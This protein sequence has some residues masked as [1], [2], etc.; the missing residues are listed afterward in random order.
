MGNGIDPDKSSLQQIDILLPEFEDPND[1]LEVQ[2][3]PLA[4]ITNTGYQRKDDIIFQQQLRSGYIPR[5]SF[6][7]KTKLIEMMGALDSGLIV[8]QH[9]FGHYALGFDATYWQYNEEKGYFENKNPSLGKNVQS[10][11]SARTIYPSWTTWL[12]LYEQSYLYKNS[13][14]QLVWRSA[15]HELKS[16]WE[17]K[18]DY[19]APVLSPEIPLSSGTDSI[20]A[21]GFSAI[22]AYIQSI[23]SHP[24]PGQAIAIDTFYGTKL[25]EYYNVKSQ[26]EAD[27]SQ[28]GTSNQITV[29]FENVIHS[30]KKNPTKQ[31]KDSAFLTAVLF[32]KFKKALSIDL[33][34]HSVTFANG[35]DAL[36][37]LDFVFDRPNIATPTFNDPAYTSMSYYLAGLDTPNLVSDDVI[38][39]TQWA[40]KAWDELYRKKEALD[41]GAIGNLKIGTIDKSIPFGLIHEYYKVLVPLDSVDESTGKGIATVVSVSDFSTLGENNPSYADHVPFARIQN[42]N[43]LLSLD[44]PPGYRI[45]NAQELTEFYTSGVATLEVMSADPARGEQKHFPLRFEGDEEHFVMGQTEGGAPVPVL[46]LWKIDQYMR[47]KESVGQIDAKEIDFDLDGDG[48]GLDQSYTHSEILELIDFLSVN[49]GIQ[50]GT[51]FQIGVKQGT[52]PNI[53]S[54]GQKARHYVARIDSSIL[55]SGISDIDFFLDQYKGKPDNTTINFE[56]ATFGVNSTTVGELK[57]YRQWFAARLSG[58]TEAI[59]EVEEN[60]RAAETAPKVQLDGLW[61]QIMLGRFSAVTMVINLLM[62]WWMMRYQK[63][64]MELAEKQM[65]MM[66]DQYKLI[67]GELDRDD[68]IKIMKDT[69]P[70]KLETAF[71]KYQHTGNFDLFVTGRLPEVHTFL[72]RTTLTNWKPREGNATGYAIMAPGGTGKDFLI[73]AYVQAKVSGYYPLSN[74]Q[75]LQ[76]FSDGEL[77]RY[78]AGKITYQ[79]LISKYG[80]ELPRELRLRWTD[81]AGIQHL[82]FS[83]HDQTTQWTDAH[84]KKHTGFAKKQP[85]IADMKYHELFADFDPRRFQAGT[86]F[87]GTAEKKSKVI[88]EV[89]AD[90]EGFPEYAD[91]VAI[92]NEGADAMSVGRNS[93]TGS[94]GVIKD[95]KEIVGRG[96]LRHVMLF[97]NVDEHK[98]FSPG[99]TRDEQQIRR[100]P[101]LYTEGFNDMSIE[102]T[103]V[104]ILHHLLKKLRDDKK[105]Q[106]LF[107]GDRSELIALAKK[108]AIE[109]GRFFPAVGNP[110]RSFMLVSN[111]LASIHDRAM[112]QQLGPQRG[113]NIQ[114]LDVFTTIMP[115]AVTG[116]LVAEI[117]ETMSSLTKDN[118]LTLV[119]LKAEYTRVLT[120]T[121]GSIDQR[122]STVPHPNIMDYFNHKTESPLLRDT[123]NGET[124]QDYVSRI[125]A[126]HRFVQSIDKS[127]KEESRPFSQK[128]PARRALNIEERAL[129]R[130]KIIS[131]LAYGTEACDEAGEN[132]RILL[133]T[134]VPLGSAIPTV[135]S[136][137]SENEKQAAFLFDQLQTLLFE[138]KLA[139]ASPDQVRGAIDYRVLFRVFSEANNGEKSI[140]TV[141]MRRLVENFLNQ[142]KGLES[143]EFYK[144][145]LD[146]FSTFLT[147]IRSELE[148]KATPEEKQAHLVTKLYEHMKLQRDKVLDQEI[149]PEQ[150]E[151]LLKQQLK[152]EKQS[153]LGDAEGYKQALIAKK[154][155]LIGLV[156]SIIASSKYTRDSNEIQPIIRK[157]ERLTSTSNERL[158]LENLDIVQTIESVFE[159][160]LQNKKDIL[161]GNRNVRSFGSAA[162]PHWSD[163]VQRGINHFNRDQITSFTDFLLGALDKND[164]LTISDAIKQQEE[165][166]KSL[167]REQTT[168]QTTTT[169]SPTNSTQTGSVVSLPQ[170]ATT[171]PPEKPSVQTDKRL[172]D[173]FEKLGLP[174]NTLIDERAAYYTSK[175]KDDAYTELNQLITAQQNGTSESLL[176]ALSQLGIK[177]E[178]ESTPLLN[179]DTLITN[180]TAEFRKLSLSIDGTTLDAYEDLREYGTEQALQDFLNVLKMPS[181]DLDARNKLARIQDALVSTYNRSENFKPGFTPDQREEILTGLRAEFKKTTSPQESADSLIQRYFLNAPTSAYKF[182]EEIEI[183]SIQDADTE[184]LVRCIYQSIAK[185]KF[186]LREKPYMIKAHEDLS[187]KL[188]FAK[189]YLESKKSDG[190]KAAHFD[191]ILSDEITRNFETIFENKAGIETLIGSTQDFVRGLTANLADQLSDPTNFLNTNNNSKKHH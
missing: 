182:W 71:E 166:D 143:D 177:K 169:P 151:E 59:R 84:G 155:K 159:Q 69:M 98:V 189:A 175:P 48:N 178:A 37:A 126:L 24:K 14:G 92:T 53:R 65:K 35:Q 168:S 127:T 63:Q 32:G 153:R 157:I 149:S 147:Q 184:N 12:P 164:A 81:H 176:A 125:V 7:G 21:A 40:W 11:S 82:G 109:S 156:D 180:I 187:L 129:L 17:G 144:Q 88:K 174:I 114:S 44:I 19:G 116:Q 28:N 64:A 181:T 162:N 104:T 118:G 47:Q 60:L 152:A 136:N 122:P 78:L 18:P 186:A 110:S 56:R 26:L 107:S 85:S 128:E 139:I 103:T 4:V 2:T 31:D 150:E 77:D 173:L 106:T 101:F 27:I 135:D 36:Q 96:L 74:E 76:A 49:N 57:L 73:E 134:F 58:N 160:I 145:R 45:P 191:R 6:V 185:I 111:F 115:D 20:G 23:L 66:G 172:R 39:K 131:V 133:G 1:G 61:E 97:A 54:D 146:T 163:L 165:N 183:L 30:L 117:R 158:N 99:G 95:T 102:D 86:T 22:E 41:S 171:P 16:N 140:P 119:D 15:T 121:F 8:H 91:M 179:R 141:T 42:Y 62:F 43:D 67:S 80:T 38:T 100:Y 120:E 154:D 72:E 105:L 75:Y 108:I 142:Q 9:Q 33:A 170:S 137:S 55:E 130:R 113:L 90:P 87:Q 79:N 29:S 5:T 83:I 123:E 132:T 52:Q 188:I 46:Q 94:E 25:S 34:N 89:L 148:S 93:M 3:S 124:A 190:D 51:L 50:Y 138:N 112:I 167:R 68:K 10:E 70:D 161:D 13:S